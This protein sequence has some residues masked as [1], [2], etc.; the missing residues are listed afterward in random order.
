MWLY[1]ARGLELYEEVTRLPGYYL[2]SRERDLLREHAPDIAARVPARTLVELGAGLPKNVRLLLDA[3]P[4]LERFVPLDV[5]EAAVRANATDVASAYPHLLVEPVAGDFERDLDSLPGAAVTLVAFLG[6]TIGNLS[7]TRRS[8]FLTCVAGALAPADAFLLGLDLVKDRARLEAAYNDPRGVTEAFVR[9]A[10]TTV[11]H[12]LGAEFDQKRFEYEA[13][14]DAEHEWMDIGFRARIRHTVWVDALELEVP[15]E[16]GE[17]LRAEISAK[18]RR[19]QVEEEAPDAGLRIDEWW[20]DEAQ[21]Y[22]LAL[23]SPR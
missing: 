7:P 15:F 1:D 14:W 3:F 2:P 22:A 11:N 9:N 12:E 17:R 5:N 23:L 4:S 18:F 6:S 20:S 16:P 19:D 8:R 10:L 21:D 13:S